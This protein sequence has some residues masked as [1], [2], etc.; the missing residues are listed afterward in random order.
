MNE[1][2]YMSFWIGFDNSPGACLH[3]KI[4]GMVVLSAVC[5]AGGIRAE[6]G[7]AG[8]P[9]A[10]DS[11]YTRPAYFSTRPSSTSTLVQSVDRLGPVGIG[12]ELHPPA[13][14][15]KVKHVEPGSPAASTGKLL[16]G[17]II[18]SINGQKLQAI[19]PR[20]QLGEMIAKA[21]ASD[22]CVVLSVR[23]SEESPVQ[24]VTV[25][26]PVLGAYSET[27]PLNCAKSDK[28]VRDL[29]ARL[30]ADGWDGN[31]GL[32]GPRMLFLLSTGD[33]KDLD[34]V[35][36]WVQKTIEKNLN[37]GEGSLAYQWSVG[38]GAPA[39]AEYYLRTGDTSVL[40]LMGKIA[41][42]VRKTM[43][44]DGWGGRGLAGHHMGLAGTSTLTFLLL[45]RQCG[46]EMDEGML[47]TALQHY[48]R[49]AGRG[50][51]PYM[52]AYPEAT[53]TDN[54]RNAMLAFAMK[55]AGALLPDER[56]D[57]Y[58][59]ASDIAAMHSFY[60]TSYMLHG[61]TGGGIGEVWR[62]AGMGLMFEKK[63]AQ[64]RDFMNSRAWWYDL[65]RRYDGSF[66][67]LGGESYDKESWGVTI[68]LT[69]TA[70]RKQ[71]C[72]F[73]APR[74]QY[75]TYHTIPERPWGTVADND[76]L[77]LEA[78]AD[79][80]GK[81]KN[82]DH[83]TVFTD[84]GLPFN[85]IMESEN[86]SDAFLIEYAHHPQ[87][88][89]R[90]IVAG[91]IYSTRR[92]HLIPALLNANDAR[93]RY[94]GVSAM[95]LPAVSSRPEKCD[96]GFPM[97][98]MTDE[99]MARL[100]EML[101]DK[102]ESWFVVDHILRLMSRREAGELA[103]HMDRINYFL[104]HDEPWLRHSALQ[105]MITLAVDNRFSKEA[106]AAIEQHV[107]NF[108]R[109]PSG[110][111]MLAKTLVDADPAIRKAGLETLGNVY[112]AYP[113]KNANPSG[114][115]HPQSSSW[116]LSCVAEAISLV[117]GG[118]ET[119]YEV[120][121]K[122][123]PDVA[124]AHSTTFLGASDIASYGETL[125]HAVRD[126]ILN[127]LI[128]AYLAKNRK[129]IQIDAAGEKI[130]PAVS[131]LGGSG[132]REGLSDL[133]SKAGV[134]DYDWHN[135]GPERDQIKWA[136]FSFDPVET[137]NWDSGDARFRK[138]TMPTGME[139]WM[140]KEFEAGKAGWKEGFAPFAAVDGKLLPQSPSCP[141]SF[142]RC[143]DQPNTL[144]EKEVLLLR[145]VIRLPEIKEGHRYRLLLGG[146]SHVGSGDGYE[147][148]VNGEKTV[149][150]DQGTGRREGGVPK[151]YLLPQAMM[152]KLSGSD[153]Q[154]AV[155]TF[156][157][158][159]PRSGEKV[160]YITLYLE[161]MKLPPVDGDALRNALLRIPMTCAEW[162]A[163][164]DPASEKE[165]DDG[166][167]TYD[168]KFQA[169]KAVLG[170]WQL[171]GYLTSDDDP[172]GV[173][174]LDK[175]VRARFKSIRFKEAGMTDSADLIWS[176]NMLMDLDG[177]QALRI[178]SKT[179]DGENVLCIENG[180]FN[181][182]GGADWKSPLLVFKK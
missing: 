173:K 100:Y 4:L 35:R 26:I 106:L 158:K 179:I 89:F 48:Y 52:D 75:A 3:A 37:F 109:A 121:S 20:I 114:G 119:L 135:F 103:A 141:S 7:A 19:D 118:L 129:Q 49:F 43:Y 107:P 91:K 5:L 82:Y 16:A 126:A 162:Q 15:M 53:F 92:F 84:S 93:V 32:N 143:S 77:D 112:L 134:K 23:D 71:L 98:Q 123:Y 39:L 40:P 47:Q 73:G 133:Y 117:P 45:A 60:S 176:G 46:V 68:G 113:G 177:A 172:T 153:V 27:W 171:V 175:S 94:V 29:A 11:F 2:T 105:A 166:K 149:A 67:V 8:K 174:P 169:N 155:K 101:E 51:N 56:N 74:S 12:I 14:V 132:A 65:S 31:I 139:N 85:R 164:Q 104:G 86:V 138:V 97:D 168:G 167:F 150:S 127:D 54:G 30:M 9:P 79:K 61:H 38:W 156:L 144:W 120:S 125:Q 115:L 159:H 99:V 10:Q 111:Q 44:H 50:T 96:P 131:T 145:S 36:G 33:D 122:R 130:L 62:S 81:I 163:L 58:E 76:F 157:R 108:V 18:E 136:Y 182:D 148:Y 140:A 25:K 69:Y 180:G 57:I 165:P 95:R 147:I 17:Q 87:H 161:E 55:A 137:Q 34:V 151:G 90:S 116:Y 152:E 83:E 146:R 142:C 102:E 28:I 110:L 160:G 13:F 6:E 1:E 70:P 24:Q 59:Q 128:P 154:I 78:A 66:G 178:T 88:H 80:G 64:Y 63:P 42:A 21:E 181:A 72:I 22:G 124:L 41:A 170:D